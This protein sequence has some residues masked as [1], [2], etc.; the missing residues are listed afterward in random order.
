MQAPILFQGL[1]KMPKTRLTE[2][3]HGSVNVNVTKGKGGRGR[4]G[5]NGSKNKSRDPNE[6]EPCYLPRHKGHTNKDCAVQ[7]LDK[8]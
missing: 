8:L 3:D 4:G 6:P 7:K 2:A 1:C 5:R